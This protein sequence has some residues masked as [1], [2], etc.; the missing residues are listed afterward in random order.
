MVIKINDDFRKNGLKDGSDLKRACGNGGIDAGMIALGL[1]LYAVGV[2]IFFAMTA[3]GMMLQGAFILVPFGLVGS[4][5][6]AAGYIMRI[7]KLGTYLD[8]FVK[9]TGYTR[10][11]LIDYER[12][13]REEDTVIISSRKKINKEACKN[14]GIVTRHW[15]KVPSYRYQIFKLADIAAFWHLKKQYYR[16]TMFDSALMIV[17][18]GGTIECIAMNPPLV[19]ECM[20]EIEK[21]NP[22]A[23]T[24]Q[25]FSYQGQAYD[26]MKQPQEVASIYREEFKRQMG[27]M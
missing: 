1:C 7:K 21:R 4:I 10:E 2:L 27:A 22:V 26:V 6:F 15:F 25:N 19:Q 3:S 5:L 18:S 8:Y 23:I 17:T 13:V 24:V 11:E 9:R 12:E 20:A 16:G 14:A